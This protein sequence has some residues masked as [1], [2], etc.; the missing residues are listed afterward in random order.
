MTIGD[1]QIRKATVADAPA[2]LACLAAAFEPY[3]DQYTPGAFA[4]TVLDSQRVRDRLHEMCLFA[5]FSGGD[6]A[7]TIGCGVNGAEGHIRGMAVLPDWEGK[8]LAS[9]L[10]EAAEAELRRKGCEYVTLDTTEPL[11]R[12]MRFYEKHGYRVTGKVIDFFGMRLH[13][14]SKPL[15]N[16]AGSSE[17]DQ[18][19]E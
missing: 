17:G 6:I 2:I 4:D 13:E 12:A 15:T 3:R 18:A 7:G 19:R 5:A 8:S 11:Q 16:S 1:H 10:L 14:Y 9:G